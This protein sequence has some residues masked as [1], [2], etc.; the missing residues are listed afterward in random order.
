MIK[1]LKKQILTLQTGRQ[2]M[3]KIKNAAKEIIA[4]SNKALEKLLKSKS[5]NILIKENNFKEENIDK[6]IIQI[7]LMEQIILN[8]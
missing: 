6:K 2:W 5:P 7:I 1:Y 8:F 3:L 4:R